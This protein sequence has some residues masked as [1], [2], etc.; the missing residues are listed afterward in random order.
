[1]LRPEWKDRPLE[2]QLENDLGQTGSLQW[3]DG[4]VNAAPKRASATTAL[5]ILATTDLH[6]HLFPYD[7][8][9]DIPSDAVGLARTATLIEKARAEVSECILLD[10]GDF[11]QGSPM[12]DYAARE[13]NAGKS[14]PHPMIAAMNLLNYDAAALGNHDFNFGVEFLESALGDAQFPIVC[15]N[16]NGTDAIS[17]PSGMPLIRPYQIL[18]RI[19]TLSNGERRLLRIGIVGFL[20]PQITQ[21]DSEHLKGRITTRDILEAAKEAVPHL[22]AQGADLVIALAHS[23][24]GARVPQT[25]TEN[26]ATALAALPGID[27]VVAGHSHLVF[28]STDFAGM[29]GVDLAAGTVC[30]KPAVMPGCWGSHLGVIDLTLTHDAGRWHVAASHAE[31]RPILHR[32]ADWTVS[33]LVSSAPEVL[34]AVAP[35]HAATLAFVRRPIGR[36]EID[37]NTY[38]ALV[39]PTACTAIVAEAQRAFVLARLSDTALGGLPVLSASAPFKAGGRGGVTQYTDIPKGDLALRHLADL[40]LFPNTVRAVRMSGAMVADWLERSAGIFRQIVPGLQDQG[41]INPAVPCYNFDTIFGLTYRIDV[42]QP[43]RFGLLGEVINPAS[44]RIRDLALDGVPLCPDADVIVATNSYRTGG[45]GE[46]PHMTNGAQ[47]VLETDEAN[48]DVLVRHV[49]NH[50]VLTD[51]SEPPWR[52]ASMPGTSVLMETSP[53][54]LRYMGDLYGLDIGYAGPGHDG[55]ARFRIQ[56]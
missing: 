42:S 55:F 13:C 56:L 53:L 40:Y 32:H 44:R 38:F 43:P 46:F 51:A 7:Y 19:V 25:G 34:R 41:L 27:A 45:G 4:P 3:S 6:M 54:G 36:S 21:W 26:A 1:V 49:L 8:C 30:G 2:T 22:R 15:A 29:D 47:V 52:F 16:I 5:R 48:R 50:G 17:G 10:N 18:D 24:F 37:L 33:P 14:G 39:S 35:D 23:G 20:P 28:P 11:L 31:A 9:I 12:G